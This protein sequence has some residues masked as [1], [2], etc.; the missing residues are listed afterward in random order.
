MD[1]TLSPDAL[2]LRDMLRRFIEKE[3]RPL[4]SKYF[5]TGTLKPEERARLRSVI[6]QMGL[7]GATV[8]AGFDGGELDLVTSCVL[9]EELGKTFIPLEIGDI[10]PMLY[11]CQGEQI[12]RFLKPVLSGSR[13]VFLAA[14]EPGAIRPEDWLTC[15][16]QMDDRFI[17][18]GAKQLGAIP[19]P[20][21]FLVVFAKAPSGYTAFLLDADRTGLEI[22]ANGGPAVLELNECSVGSE[23][24]LGECGK[25][26]T[27]GAEEAPRGWIRIGARYVGFVDRLIEMSAA[28]ARDWVALGSPLKDRPAIQRMLAEMQVQMESCRWLVYHAAWLGDQQESLRIPSAKVRLACG[29]MLQKAAEYGTM[30]FGGPGPVSQTDVR[31]LLMS[32]L[33]DTIIEMILASARAIVASHVLASSQRS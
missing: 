31:Q 13:R 17:L 20:Q 29:E 7:W 18:N 6:E 9:E 25:A 26:L 5:S 2:M 3:V 4:E 28:Y 30:I 19:Q 27:L 16:A 23:A 14:R 1:F 24:I 33:P 10:P 22:K 15:A 8:P 11:A 21:D 12:K 32:A